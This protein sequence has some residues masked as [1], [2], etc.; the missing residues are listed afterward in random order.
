MATVAART[1][2]K[3]TKRNRLTALMLT[4]FVCGMV[5]LAFASVPLYRLFCQIT[6]YGGTPRIAE[7]PLAAPTED[8]PPIKV[9][10]DA[11]VNAALPWRFR[12]EQREVTVP[13]GEQTLAFYTAQNVSDTSVVGT[14]T[15][16]VTP[17]K[18][19]PYFAKI[20]CFCFTEQRLEPGKE[21][22]MPVAFFVDPAIL[23]DPNT[24]EVTTITLSYTFFLAD[25][26]GDAIEN[27]AT[28]DREPPAAEI[29][30]A[31]LT[32]GVR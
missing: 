19:A 30:A 24:Q 4:G 5:G 31:V 7:V 22:S 26:N 18:A 12:P 13:M 27:A 1:Q 10:F 15:F 16:N 23:E 25:E 11:N 29:R 3:K 21:M 28:L 9:R 32:P 2:D 8:T 6:G 20:E 14:A 17:H